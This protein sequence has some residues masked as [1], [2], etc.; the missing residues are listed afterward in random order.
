MPPE[1]IAMAVCSRGNGSWTLMLGSVGTYSRSV[2]YSQTSMLLQT[3]DK[4][5]K[6]ELKL[7]LE[8]NGSNCSLHCHDTECHLGTFHSKKYLCED[9]G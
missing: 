8:I 4:I 3:I 1:K 6:S 9:T 2:N 7:G 5:S